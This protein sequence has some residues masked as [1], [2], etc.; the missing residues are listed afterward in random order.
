M[1]KGMNCV[2]NAVFFAI[3]LN[4]VLPMLI[5]P[6]ATQEEK[7]PKE[8]AKSLSMKAQF[9]HMIVH[10]NQV[11]FMSS[12]IIALIVGLAVFLG[13]KFKPCE[14]LVKLFK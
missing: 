8:G 7:Q 10:H 6:F 11:I 5:S 12:L 13:Y 1:S 3:V 9:M 4:I 14:R 2:M